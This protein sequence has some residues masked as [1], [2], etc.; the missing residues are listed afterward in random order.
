MVCSGYAPSRL[1]AALLV[2]CLALILAACIPYKPTL[3]LEKS[4]HSIPVS[5][6]VEMF[7]DASPPDDKEDLAEGTVSQTKSMEGDLSALV[8]RAIVADFS[9]AAVFRSIG[10]HAAHPDLI[11]SGTIRRFYG[12]A[13]IPSWALIP[14]LGWAVSAFASPV[15]AWQ[16]EVDLEVR[17]A[18]PDGLVLGV[19]RGRAAYQEMAGHDSRYWSMP[20]YPAH[21]RLNRAFTEAVGQIRDQMVKDR[22]LLLTGL[23]KK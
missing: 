8:T 16:G 20:L 19:Y 5:V 2:G 22:E 6:A 10:R 7:R 3:A 1:V 18:T 17:L 11:L 14:G 12:Q 9:A 4:V 23:M 21:V 13:T 15:Q